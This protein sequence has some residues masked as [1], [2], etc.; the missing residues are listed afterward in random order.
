[1]HK[2]LIMQKVKYNFFLLTLR[3]FLIMRDLQLLGGAFLANFN[4][5]KNKADILHLNRRSKRLI[6]ALVLLLTFS[7][8]I[9]VPAILK[10]KTDNTHINSSEKII[11]PSDK[12]AIKNTNNETK[13][14]SKTY[15][16]TENDYGYWGEQTYD[17]GYIITGS[18]SNDPYD[19]DVWL[20]KTDS[21][22]SLIWEKTYGAGSY[23][24]GYCVQQTFDEGYIIIGRTSSYGVGSSDVWLIKTDISGKM[25]WDKTFGGK[26]IDLGHCILQTSDLGYIIVGET[27]SFGAGEGDV[28]LIKTDVN[29][30]MIWNKTFGGTLTDRGL[31]VVLTT[32]GGYIITGYIEFPDDVVNYDE[33]LLIK[34]DENGTLEWKQAF[35]SGRG[36]YVVETNDG[37]YIIS[38]YAFGSGNKSSFSDVWLIKTDENGNKEWS[39]TYGWS[40]DNLGFC[41]KQTNDGGYIITGHAQSYPN[42]VQYDEVL[43]IK[44]DENGTLEWKQTFGD[45]RGQCI[46]TT[47]DGGYIVTGYTYSYGADAD[48]W[49]IKTDENGVIEAPTPPENPPSDN[50]P[51]RDIAIKYSSDFY[52]FLAS[53]FA[54]VTS[55]LVY[56]FFVNRERVKI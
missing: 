47:A 42:G 29:G 51:S 55:F 18:Y 11:K 28:W 41:V 6:I 22:G 45:G 37:G 32:D 10:I 27:F 9:I 48:V 52:L 20:I 38:G 33:V 54:L 4:R 17:G 24:Q 2:K 7:I 30:N 44:T 53:I 21:N 1:M 34:T 5:L 46:A 50:P 23:E 26:S 36:K 49:L 35:G 13:R 43:L 39:K 8:A 31:S 15:G 16:G 56:F 14:W 25:L 12:I 19:H 40:E 3:I